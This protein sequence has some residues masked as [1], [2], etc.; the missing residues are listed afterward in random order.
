MEVIK[1]M[2]P[3][4]P[5]TQRYL[6]RYGEKLVAVRYRHD[7]KRNRQ[8]TTIELVVDEREMPLT[9]KRVD[10]NAKIRAVRIAPHQKDEL[11]RLKAADAQW[12]EKRKVWWLPEKR[13]RIMR[14]KD[15]MVSGLAYP[16]ID[17][18]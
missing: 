13:V 7:P 16:D 15:Y 5:G 3:G 12:D 4:R 9:D 14:L 17:N 11:R 8:L 1:T 6:R 10:E 2:R 18:D